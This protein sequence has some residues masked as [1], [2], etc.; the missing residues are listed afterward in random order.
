MVDSYSMHD[1]FY[2]YSTVLVGRL[3]GQMAEALNLRREWMSSTAGS[4]LSLPIF[5]SP[6]SSL[7]LLI[8]VR[9]SGLKY[10][11]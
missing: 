2:I 11:S 7:C 8:L 6:T 4:V 5:I 10:V 3:I 1:V 9:L